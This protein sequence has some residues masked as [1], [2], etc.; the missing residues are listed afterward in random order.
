MSSSVRDIL[1]KIF[2]VEFVLKSYIQRHIKGVPPKYTYSEESGVNPAFQRIEEVDVLLNPNEKRIFALRGDF[3][4]ATGVK[5]SEQQHGYHGLKETFKKSQYS[6]LNWKDRYGHPSLAIADNKYDGTVLYAGF[7][8]QRSGYLEVFLSS[9]RYNRCNRI[10]EGIFPLTKEQ[11][12]VIESYL[13]LKFQK[14]YGL[15]K[16]IF[17]DTTPEQDDIDSALFFKNKPFPKRKS[18]RIYQSSA[19]S[20]AVIIAHSDS[21]FENAQHYIKSTIP[22]VSPKYSY[23]D[24]GSINPGYQEITSIHSPLKPQE[25]RIWAL[26]SDF[27]LATGVKNAYEKEY[28]YTGF[29]NSFSKSLHS[30]INWKDRYGHPSLTLPEGDYDGSVFY[31]GYVCQRKGY[32]Q[33]YLVSGRFERND[34]NEEQTRILEAY[35]AAQFQT[36]Y[37]NQEIVFDYGDSNNPS[38]H[39]TF[40]SDGLFEKNNPQRRYNQSSIQ[41]ILQNIPIAQNDKVEKNQYFSI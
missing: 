4:L 9:G 21:C 20:E 24:E 23:S 41:N 33:V 16:I 30:F 27:I 10:E 8:C 1:S 3:I 34:L 5:N 2:N 14:A 31:A 6:Y 18:S 32:L 40:F 26:R 28:G 38:Y 13:S 7:I 29:K 37:G 19:I 17:Y 15:Q 12:H 35:I 25:K 22:P 11:T 36:A 39:A